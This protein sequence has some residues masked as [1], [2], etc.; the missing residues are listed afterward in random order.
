MLKDGVDLDGI[1]YLARKSTSSTS[2]EKN[3]R[4]AKG[5]LAKPNPSRRDE[6]LST[7]IIYCNVLFLSLSLSFKHDPHDIQGTHGT[8]GR[9]RERS[10]AARFVSQ[11]LRCLLLLRM[12]M[13]ALNSTMV[14]AEMRLST[15]GCPAPYRRVSRGN[16]EPCLWVHPWRVR[17]PGQL[18]VPMRLHERLEL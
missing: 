10:E 17:E 18:Q 9:S 11:P 16:R 7:N 8:H 15:G 2:C 4:G 12:G 14:L 6:E 13:G 1:C 3:R 5:T